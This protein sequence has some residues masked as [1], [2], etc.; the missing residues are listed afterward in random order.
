MN[1]HEKINK[2]LA[3]FALG[4]LS[5]EQSSDVE[6]HLTDCAECAKELE[7][8]RAV[9]ECADGMSHLTADDQLCELAKQR[10]LTAAASE[11]TTKA[12]GALEIIWRPIMRSKNL[13]YTAA[14]AVIIVAAVVGLNSFLGGTISFAQV[15]KP[16]LNA[17]TIV[18]DLVIGNNEDS[19]VMHEEVSGSRI[20]RTISNMP[21]LVMILDLDD[22]KMLALDTHGKTAGYV[23]LGQVGEKTQNYIESVR[24]IIV[25]L[26]N[27]PDIEKLPEREV[28][29]KRAIGFK[30][31]NAREK[32]TIWA[33]P[34]TALPIRIELE[35]GQMCVIFKDFEFDPQIEEISMDVPPGYT[36][37]QTQSDLSDPSEQ[38]FVES[39]R[40]WAEIVLDGTFPDAVS[41]EDYMKDVAI[42]GQKIPQL[43]LPD[44]EKEQLGGKFGRGILFFQNFEMRGEW[45]YG[46]KGTRLGDADKAIF[47][48]LPEGSQAYRVI[49]GDLHV[50]D[51]APEN[52]PE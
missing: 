1:T 33:D 21:A 46:G 12:R 19:P 26:Q 41:T 30:G 3:G 48:Y 42:L 13:R 23:D 9:L 18:F 44:S 2:L 39:L 20:K 47:W 4:E 28:D 25:E 32:I 52:L 37:D 22:N 51:V 36:L 14:A 35:I 24:K 11:Q 6:A 34:R 49:Y 10:I 38:D 16:I 8:M 45:H 7:D 29:G 5:P 50:A 31:G 17:R 15:V 27:G 43:D 40:I